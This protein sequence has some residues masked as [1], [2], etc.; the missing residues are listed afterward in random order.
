MCLLFDQG[1]S[2]G[3]LMKTKTKF[4]LWIPGF[5]LCVV[6]VAIFVAAEIFINKV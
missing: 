1:G 4:K 6:V 2:L 3:E 5:I